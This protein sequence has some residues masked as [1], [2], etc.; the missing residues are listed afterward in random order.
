MVASPV[1]ERKLW[2]V[3]IYRTRHAAFLSI[4]E[5]V[6]LAEL[7]GLRG[8]LKFP[9]PKLEE[10]E[11]LAVDPATLP[12]ERRLVIEAYEARLVHNEAAEEQLVE[13]DRALDAKIRN[14][15]SR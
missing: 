12:Y 6:P 9:R 7:I 11:T 2:I 15:F 1:S 3:R 14:L 4:I 10:L 8:K 5:T 13:A